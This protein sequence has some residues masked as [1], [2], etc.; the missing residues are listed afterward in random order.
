MSMPNILMIMTDQHRYD[1][2]SC[3]G[4]PVLQTPN[5]DSLAQGGVLFRNA[6]TPSPVCSP[7][8]A[9]IASGMHPP[10][11]GVVTNWVPFDKDT[12]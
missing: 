11:C 5:I 2:L 12:D 7:A 1:R 9:A 8:R 4:D 3:T 6:Y 10:G